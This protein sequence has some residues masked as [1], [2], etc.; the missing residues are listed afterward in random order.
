METEDLAVMDPQG[1]GAPVDEDT[2][3]V[4]HEGQV[5]R[6]PAPL[7]GAF[8][9]N[10]DY[11]RKTQELAEHRRALAQ[12]R[13]HLD[14]RSNALAA[15][16]ELR[17]AMHA[18][19]EQLAAFQDVD[20]DTFAA[21]DPQGAQALWG[22]F[23]ALAHARERYEWAISHHEAQGAQLAQQELA[24]QMAQTGEILSR[25][26]EGW[27][28]QVAAKLVEYAGAF[29]VTLDELREIA[30]PR[31]WKILHR[32]H[33]GDELDRQRKTAQGVEQVQAVRPA[34]SVS[35]GSAPTGAVRDNLGT[36]EWM[37]RRNE[38]TRRGR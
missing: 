16:L 30:D 15:T 20:W 9:M 24:A 36:G 18:A 23:Q 28:P 35:G 32:A 6:V 17:A 27:S 33:L 22:R 38:Q 37:R 10:A 21:E 26:I 2:C 12:D 8:L 11:T 4:E 31:L 3:E 14:S 19:D 29:G 1:V 13:A 34:V 7:K 25:E 5:Y